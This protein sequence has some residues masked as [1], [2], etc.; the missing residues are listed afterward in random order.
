MEEHQQYLLF[1]S[2]S[3]SDWSSNKEH[4]EKYERWNPF[5]QWVLHVWLTKNS[6]NNQS[7]VL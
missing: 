4:Q 5:D 2:A 3:D 7:F 1:E 6:T